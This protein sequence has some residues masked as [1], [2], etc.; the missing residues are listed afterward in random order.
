VLAQGL[1]GFDEQP[2]QHLALGQAVVVADPGQRTCVVLGTTLFWSHYQKK[3]DDLIQKMI[4]I[5]HGLMIL[6]QDF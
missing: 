3:G 4:M 5:S 2:F 6:L 1:I